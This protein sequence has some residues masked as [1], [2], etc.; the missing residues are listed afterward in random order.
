MGRRLGVGAVLTLPLVVLEMGA[1]LGVL[2]LHHYASSA[3]SMWIEF[4]LATPVV[5]WCGWPF[6][7]RASASIQNRS[8]NMFTLIALGVSAAYLYSVAATFLPGAFPAALRGKSGHI[9]VYYEAA[10]MITVL[11]LLGQVL[12]LRARE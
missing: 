3:W 12:E 2:N 11:V 8:P 9:P 6:F 1:H 5:F 4:A 10:A 7:E